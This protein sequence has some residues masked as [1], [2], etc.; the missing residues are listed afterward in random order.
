MYQAEPIKRHAYYQWVPFVLFFQAICFYMPH[1]L[2]RSW[3][4]GKINKLVEGLQRIFLTRYMA[5]EED[6]KISANFTIYSKS[7]INKK[8][9]FTV[10]VMQEFLLKISLFPQISR[11]KSAFMKQIEINRN[12]ANKYILCEMLNLINVIFQIYITDKFLSGNFLYLGVDFIRDDFKGIMDTLDIVFPKVTK[13]HFHKYGASGTIQQHDALCVMALNVIN[14]KIY[15][16][17]WFWFVIL[18]VVSTL[19]L[20]WRAFTMFMHSR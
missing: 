18:L 2:W 10:T 7:T 6:M 12:W 11:I 20:L 1:L 9:S 13:C 5:K 4:G 19:A 16:F 15:V 14:E 17:L 8:V 3:E